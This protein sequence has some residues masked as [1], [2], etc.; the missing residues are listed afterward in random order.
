MFAPKYINTNIIHQQNLQYSKQL[1]EKKLQYIKSRKSDLSSLNLQDPSKQM[2]IKSRWK[3]LSNSNFHLVRTEQIRI[4][5]SKILEKLLDISLKKHPSFRSQNKN[6]IKNLNHYSR[7][8]AAE[9]LNYEN[10]K[11]AERIVNKSPQIQIK[12]FN[13]D[14]RNHSQLKKR[15]SR[16]NIL[17]QR[18]IPGMRRCA[19][20]CVDDLQN[21]SLK[22]EKNVPER[23][24]SPCLREQV[25]ASNNTIEEE[26]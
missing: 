14:Y 4:Q 11:I 19:S 16:S 20:S 25:L 10:M 2:H 13:R 21:S 5:N 24:V 1:H 3:S 15:I 23:F 6:S 7:K 22:L 17:S 8:R 26:S 18:K 9:I 12:N